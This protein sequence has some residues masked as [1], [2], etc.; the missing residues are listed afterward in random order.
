ML[1]PDIM[2]YVKILS[3]VIYAGGPLNKSCGDKL[4]EH[5]KL[6][7]VC[8][9]GLSRKRH[10]AL[11]ISC[12]WFDRDWYRSVSLFGTCRLAIP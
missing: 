4:A 12:R 10:K 2:D 6:T 8:K 7:T 5:V 3:V 1:I 11:L 9:E